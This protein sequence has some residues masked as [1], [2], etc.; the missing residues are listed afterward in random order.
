MKFGL[1]LICVGFFLLTIEKV[2]VGGGKL[3]MGLEQL[4]LPFAQLSGKMRSFVVGPWAFIQTIQHVEQE[5]AEL[6]NQRA[7][8]LSVI[9]ATALKQALDREESILKQGDAQFVTTTLVQ[10]E[11]PMMPIGTRQGI[12]VGAM[13]TVHDVLVGFVTQVGTQFSQVEM[14]DNISRKISVRVREVEAVG[15]LER[16]VGE[17][18]LT[19]VKPDVKLSADQTITTFGSSDGV[20]PYVPIARVKHVL[21]SPSDPFQR[22]S[23]ELLILP[24]DGDV[25]RVLQHGEAQ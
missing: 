6:R 23:V 25:V 4:S 12:Q 14:V 7:K 16:E 2:G 19:H 9:G 5:N 11:Q 17:L 21:S 1:T 22:A 10:S 20:L 15:L 8:L 18:M 13:V 24:K 3:R